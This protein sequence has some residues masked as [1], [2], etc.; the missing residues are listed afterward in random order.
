MHTCM[1]AWIHA[2]IHTYNIHTYIVIYITDTPHLYTHIIEHTY[3]H[4]C[5]HA[6]MH[7]Y[8]NTCMLDGW[9]DVCVYY[10]EQ[11]RRYAYDWR[12][13]SRRSLE[14]L[15]W[16][17]RPRWRR[18]GTPLKGRLPSSASPRWRHS[19]SPSLMDPYRGLYHGYREGFAE[20]WPY[21]DCS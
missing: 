3:M 19:P 15:L 7:A 17:R 11:I 6:G 14:S 1:H 12:F 5:T 2:D 10:V 13:A 9:M 20:P 16:R 4:S 18:S 21:P 8:V